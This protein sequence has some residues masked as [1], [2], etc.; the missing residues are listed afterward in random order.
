MILNRHPLSIAEANEYITD[1]GENKELESYIKKFKKLENKEAIKLRGELESLNNHKLKSE[2][3]VKII[4]FLPEDSEDLNKILLETSLSEEEAN[5][6]L[7][8]VKN[9]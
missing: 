3:I 1:F 5:A 4:D 8:I 7:S 9:Y 2:D 6:I